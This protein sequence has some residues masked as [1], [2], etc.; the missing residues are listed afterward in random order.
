MDQLHEWILFCVQPAN[1]KLG[2]PLLSYK[3]TVVTE[4]LCKKSSQSVT[5][6]FALPMTSIKGL[7]INIHYFY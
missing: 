4:C 6:I 5:L 7:F 2:S 3:V 1:Y